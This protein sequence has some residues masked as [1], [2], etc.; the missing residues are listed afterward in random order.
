MCADHD[1]RARIE[2]FLGYGY[3]PEPEWT[4]EQ[5][6]FADMLCDRGRVTV[7]A[8]APA[9][10][11]VRQGAA[12]WQAGFEEIP[13]GRQVVPLSGG[14]DSRII[15][16]ELLHRGLRDETIAFTF[17]VPGALDYEIGRRVAEAVGVEHVAVDF[18]GVELRREDLVRTAG[19]TPAWGW[20]FDSHFTRLCVALFPPDATVWSGYIGGTLCG[21]VLPEH[22]HE[23]WTDALVLFHRKN[24]FVKSADL[25]SPTSDYRDWLPAHPL[26]DTQDLCFDDQAALLIRQLLCIRPAAAAA[27]GKP[28]T[29]FLSPSWRSYVL[30]LP[31]DVRRGRAMYWRVI[32]HLYPQLCALPEK[33]REGLPLGTPPRRLRLRQLRKRGFA[34]L[35]RVLRQPSRRT[36]Q[37][38]N[39]IDYHEGIRVRDD[40]RSLVRDALTSLRK[41]GVAD[42]IDMEGLWSRHQSRQRNHGDALTLL[43]ALDIHLEV[44]DRRGTGVGSGGELAGQG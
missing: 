18:A 27:Y 2:A 41:R 19:E 22:P 25:V 44:L 20:L 9:E 30:S 36:R 14:L 31:Y 1:L 42:W 23:T 39:Y 15:L 12:C 33:D 34:R 21:A 40:L 4:D 6:R 37:W 8:D 17:G 26:V 43:T 13:D 11:L 35:A 24:R 32:E 38:A 7:D 29:P 5:R 10:D 3:C 28:R 16:G